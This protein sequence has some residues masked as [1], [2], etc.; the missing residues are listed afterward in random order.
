MIVKKLFSNLIKAF[1]LP[2]NDNK[3]NDQVKVDR[4]KISNKTDYLILP[5][6]TTRPRDDVENLLK[7][8]KINGGFFIRELESPL[9]ELE[10]ELSVYYKSNVYHFRI[11]IDEYEQCSIENRFKVIY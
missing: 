8:L 6:F 7:Q 2:N 10:Y 3:I 4:V 11:Q 9:E 1:K 5:Y